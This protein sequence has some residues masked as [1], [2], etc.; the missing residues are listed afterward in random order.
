MNNIKLSLILEFSK[1]TKRISFGSS[2]FL[3]L[4]CHN[5]LREKCVKLRVVFI[6]VT[7][8]FSLGDWV[9]SRFRLLM[10]RLLLHVSPTYNV[11]R[12]TYIVFPDD[13]AKGKRFSWCYSSCSYC[14][15]CG[16][17]SYCSCSSCVV[18]VVAVV[19]VVV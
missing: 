7:R 5:W 15:C 2:V 16:S 11:L 1:G 3:L 19:L 17:C 8:C 14:S 12:H 13:L 9:W 6:K 4:V 18:P 10:I